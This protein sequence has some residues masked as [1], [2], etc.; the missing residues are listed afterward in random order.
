MCCKYIIGKP[1]M[2]CEDLSNIW[3]CCK[4]VHVCDV[5]VMNAWQLWGLKNNISQYCRLVLI[6]AINVGKFLAIVK[7]FICGKWMLVSTHILFNIWRCL[8]CS[9]VSIYGFIVILWCFY[10]CSWPNSGLVKT[11][12]GVVMNIFKHLGY[13]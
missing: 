10:Y 2:V 12:R 5:N 11:C 6:C 3:Q 13:C 1:P 9:L 4:V 7:T 8:L